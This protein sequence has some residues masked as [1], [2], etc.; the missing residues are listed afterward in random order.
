MICLIFD[1]PKDKDLDLSLVL[2][3]YINL[4]FYSIHVYLE[5][6]SFMAFD[7]LC[8]SFLANLTE[9]YISKHCIY[10]NWFL[11]MNKQEIVRKVVI[12]IE[13]EID[14]KIYQQSLLLDQLLKTKFLMIE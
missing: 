14:G 7:Y 10:E 13:T 4:I 8:N 5:T 11:M 6:I 3:I 2:R 1:S 9:I 12:F